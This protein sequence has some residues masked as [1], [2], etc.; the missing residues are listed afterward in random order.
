MSLLFHS[1]LLSWWYISSNYGRNIKALQD[2][3]NSQ[4]IKSNLKIKIHF[5]TCAITFVFM[6]TFIDSSK[7]KLRIFHIKWLLAKLK[8]RVF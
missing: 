4:S 3:V 2:K 1:F 8:K 5:K 7:L 6:F